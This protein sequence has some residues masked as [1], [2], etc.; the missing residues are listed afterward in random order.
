M[1]ICFSVVFVLIISKLAFAQYDF[2]PIDKLLKDSLSTISGQGGGC[3]LVIMKDGKTIYNK[4]FSLPLRNYSSDK[5]VPIASASKWLSAGVIMALTDAK[6]LSLNDSI[7]KYLPYF[8]NEKKQ[9]TVKQ[10]FSHTSGYGGDNVG[11]TVLT[12][13]NIS[14][15]SCVKI[16]SEVP[17]YFAPGKGLYYGG[18]GMHIAGRIAELASGIKIKSGAA[19]DTLFAMYISKP[20][21][22]TYTNYEAFGATENPRIAGG[23]QSSANEYVKYLTMLLNGGIYN[24]RQI[25]SSSAIDE[26]LKDQ[27]ENAPVIYSPY[28]KYG[29]LGVDPF[30]RYGIGNWNEVKGNNEKIIESGSQGAFGF[31]PWIDRQRNIAGVLSVYSALENVMPTY[32]ELRKLIRNIIDSPNEVRMSTASPYDFFLYQNYPNPF[33]PSTRIEYF[34]P[35]QTHIKLTVYNAMGQLVKELFNGTKQAGRHFTIFETAGIASGIYFCK[36]EYPFSNQIIK[37]ALLR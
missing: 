6:R 1:R 30:T 33:N 21:G 23:V 22:M 27:T 5:I 18:Y 25:L 2:A 19:W 11:D 35:T 8:N 36:L 24:G 17:L 34:L 9:I 16:I 4:S 14:L 26:M 3:A 15:D 31:S 10:L 7:G 37:M 29:Y 28:L 20:L 12:K 13:K 32:V